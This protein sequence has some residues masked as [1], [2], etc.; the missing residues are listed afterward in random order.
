MPSVRAPELETPL[1]WLNTDRPLRFDGELRGQVVVLDFWTYCCINCIH[2]LPDLAW[3]EHKY[4]AEPVTFIGVH[5]AKFHNEANRETIRAAILRYEIQHPVVIDD[6]MKIWRAYAARSWPTLVVIDSA[7][8]VAGQLA[9]EGNRD[10]LDKAIAA[11]L[12]SGRAA[13]TLATGPLSVQK[14]ASVRATG[15]LAFPGKVCADAANGRLY[16]ADSNHNRVVV[17]E[18]P[19]EQGRCR[20]V[21]VVGS[22]EVGRADGPAESATFNHPQGL[23]AAHGRLYVADT[24]NHLIRAIDL[25]TFEVSTAVGTGELDNDRA[26]GGMGAG[27]GINSPW[28]IAIEGS[29]L[30]VA[31]AGAHQIW[32]I[33]MP[34]GFARAFAGSGREN[35]VD[36]PT[37]TSALAQ[38]SGICAA[39]GNLYVADS[40]ASAVRR[41]DM[42]TEQVSTIIGEGL[43]SFGDVDGAAPKAKLQHPLGIAPHG[44]TLLVA[45]TYNH[46]IKRIDPGARTLTTLF[47]TGAA[48]ASTADGRPAFFEPGGLSVLGDDLYVADTNNHRILWIGL[49]SGCWRELVFEGLEPPTRSDASDEERRI[50]SPAA[51]IDPDQDVRLI[52][53][54]ALPAGMK[55]SA[56]APWSVR[57]RSGGG[58]SGGG[59]LMQQTGRADRLPIEVAIPARTGR[60]PGTWLI[61]AAMAACAE[62]DT[63]VCVPLRFA[64]RVPLE[65]GADRSI[66]VAGGTR[67]E[68]REAAG[69]L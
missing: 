16:V 31:M 69:G 29:T 33:D 8:Y 24:E 27:Q 54:P 14:D 60:V 39:G 68:R 23:A 51:A 64:W 47:G 11:A 66:V 12:A 1:G 26:G 5:S 61:D 38:P 19:D 15:G 59:T 48:G 49:A 34:V 45:D 13:G 22:G 57:V 40:E 30:Y 41:I 63:G 10:A 7:G 65:R 4:A 17:A 2:V 43:F 37:E 58:G 62:G 20:L 55:L 52:I 50:E 44:M 32:R 6:N 9:G 56:E 36:G 3:L 67:H 21:R 42:A 25:E 28:D 35:L 46:K 18:L 53:H